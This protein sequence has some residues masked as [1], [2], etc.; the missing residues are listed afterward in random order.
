MDELLEAL[1][2]ADLSERLRAQASLAGLGEPVVEPLRALLADAEAPVSVRWRAALILGA[3][4]DP[5]ALE[6]LVAALNDPQSDVRNC[7]VMALCELRH[8]GAFD[9]L[10]SC[11]LNAV[12]DEQIPYMAALTLITFDIERAQT[13]LLDALR[14]DNDAVCRAA[15]STLA[16]MKYV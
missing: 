13:F 9:A 12:E 5:R 10:C 11:V 1:N 4:G 8:T 2:H 14:S 7:A 3:T 6:P 16:F 15:M